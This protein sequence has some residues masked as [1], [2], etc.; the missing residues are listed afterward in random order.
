[1]TTSSAAPSPPATA[2]ISSPTPAIASLVY[3]KLVA[4]TLFWG[5]TFIAG[6]V[7]AQA[8]PPLT[9]ASGRFTVAAALLLL[10]VWKLEGGLPRLNR[11]QMA[12][13]AA[14][15]FFGVFLYNLCFFAALAR[16]P[17]GR[18]ALFVAL[19]PIV[20]ALASALLFRERLGPLK[21]LGIA[22]AF[23]GA[24]VVITR[25]D[26][27]GALH[28]IGQSVGM[29][30]VLMFCAISSWAAYTIIGRAALKGLTPLAA[31]TCAALWGL[32]FLAAGAAFE[33]P[34][35]AWSGFGWRIWASILYLGVFGT[36]LGFVWYYEGVK[37]IGPS[38]TAVFNN[39]V[40]VFGV[41]LASLL[42]GE[43]ILVSMVVGGALAIAGVTLTNR[44]AGRG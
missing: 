6:R 5:G 14:L 34:A 40:P 17:A 18:T 44:T 24:A 19:N 20:T 21:W 23:L 26:P 33:T 7:L 28:D 13:T 41:T 43:S 11:S 36:V 12:M 3:I 32:A 37:A 35:I 38:R 10:L 16:M 1:M 42:L 30:E 8:L 4:V 29:G 2:A 15:G 9:A 39:L 31:T 25:G 27:A 22:I